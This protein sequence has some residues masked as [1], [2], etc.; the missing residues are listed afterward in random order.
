MESDSDYMKKSKEKGK[1]NC[2]QIN[3]RNELDY[4]EYIWVEQG[5]GVYV[6]EEEDGGGIVTNRRPFEKDEFEDSVSVERKQIK[7][8]PVAKLISESYFQCAI[9]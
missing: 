9:I 2:I 5:G 7:E 1:E 8:S 6:Y 3:S 4:P